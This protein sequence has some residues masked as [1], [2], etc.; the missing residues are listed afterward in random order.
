MQCMG[1]FLT[2]C[3]QLSTDRIGAA[4]VPFVEPC[5]LV[6]FARQPRTNSSTHVVNEHPKVAQ[7]DNPPAGRRDRPARR[8]RKIRPGA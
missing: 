1:L 3:G 8:L 4:G 7:T 2:R 6:D 5:F